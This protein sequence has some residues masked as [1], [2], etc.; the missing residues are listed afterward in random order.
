METADSAALLLLDLPQGALAGI[1][2]LS[3][4]TTPR[5]QG[6]KNIPD[7]FHFAFVGESILWVQPFSR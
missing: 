1:D 2:I 4:T 6:V 3:F 5:F 7:G